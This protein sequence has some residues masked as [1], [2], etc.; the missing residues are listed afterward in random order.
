MVVQVCQ[1]LKRGGYVMDYKLFMTK[2]INS[3]IADDETVAKAVYDAVMRFSAGFLRE[4]NTTISEQTQGG[5]N[6]G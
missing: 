5:K 2:A 3:A 6:Y 4:L 1:G